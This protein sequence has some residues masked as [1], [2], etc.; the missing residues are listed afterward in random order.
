MTRQ[1][2]VIPVNDP[3][4]LSGI[5][6]A[7]LTYIEAGTT[8]V[9]N[10]VVATDVD[11]LN[12]SGAVIQITGHYVSGQDRLLFTNTA[13]ITGTWDP[14]TGTLT[15]SGLDTLA[16]Y[17]AALH[18]VAYH[19]LSANPDTT[20]RTV[21]FTVI[22]DGNLPSNTVTRN[23]TVI[24]VNNPPLLIGLEAVP[25]V[26]TEDINSFAVAPVTSTIVATDP[27]SNNASSATI[28]I[29]GN[30]MSSQ[31]TL[32][33]TNTA[34]ITG[35]WDPTTGTMTLSG[36]DSFSNYRTAIRSVEYSNLSRY[37]NP[38]PRTLTFQ[39]TD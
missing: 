9:S 35:H 29:T 39:I 28:Q 7:A 13:K 21:S 30:Y 14:T 22:D 6:T 34:K 11:S 26:Y 32:I 38:L 3:P 27:D 33:F 31:D 12:M 5:E 16:N 17:N 24:A 1:I 36:V 2:N 25:L 4:V 23:I 19:N 18:S 8:P 15:L 10:T 37:P 20:T